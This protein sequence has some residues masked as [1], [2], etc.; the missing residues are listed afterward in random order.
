MAL[1]QYQDGNWQMRSGMSWGEPA[2]IFASA[3]LAQNSL[4]SDVN[5]GAGPPKS[6]KNATRPGICNFAFFLFLDEH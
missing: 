5:D 2:L 6:D 3:G 4:R 1:I